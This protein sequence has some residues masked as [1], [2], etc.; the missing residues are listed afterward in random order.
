MEE[1][2]MADLSKIARR[3]IARVRRFIR[4]FPTRRTMTLI[5][6]VLSIVKILEATIRLFA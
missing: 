1:S 4:R 6:V 3:V 2:A 5:S